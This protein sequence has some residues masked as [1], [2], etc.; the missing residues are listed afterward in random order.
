MG[1]RGGCIEMREGISYVGE[2]NRLNHTNQPFKQHSVCCCWPQLNTLVPRCV[3]PAFMDP[4]LWAS[5]H[6]GTP[7]SNLEQGFKSDAENV[8]FLKSLPIGSTMGPSEHLGIRPG[9]HSSAPHFSNSD[10]YLMYAV[11]KSSDYSVK[12][13]D[14]H[15][16]LLILPNFIT[17]FFLLILLVTFGS[18]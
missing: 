12:C 14:L 13:V 8:A 17:F 11:V 6:V 18:K 3:S 10:N 1:E 16:E 7:P 4:G 2:Y 9:G 5:W 15:V